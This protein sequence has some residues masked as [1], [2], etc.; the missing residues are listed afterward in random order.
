MNM[1]AT[2]ARSRPVAQHCAELTRRSSRP[3][4]RAEHLAAWRRDV[5]QELAQELGQLFSG[6][7]LQASLAEPEMLG[8]SQVFEKIGPVAVNSLLRCGEGD[9]TVLLSLNHATAIALTDASFG[10]EGMLPEDPPSQLPRS[11]TMLVERVATTIAQVLALVNGADSPRGDVLLRSESATRLKPFGAS[12]EIACFTLSLSIGPFAEWNAL[13]AVANDRLEG[14][15]PGLSAQ[16]SRR[17]APSI[18]QR[19]V[20]ETFGAM[21]L[22]LE[23][24]LG[25]IDLSLD[26]LDRLA[27]GDELPLAITNELPLRT[28]GEVL[29]R[30]TVGTVEN[31][32]ALR[33]TRLTGRSGP[34]TDPQDKG[35]FA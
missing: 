1:A 21:P 14:L 19:A 17:P 4:D 33:V 11:A 15:M 31:R 25:E 29:A 23:A 9:Q 20:S 32:M 7:K 18:E 5:A 12:A 16:R 34:A 26:R 30:G 35:A 2:F 6:G 28:G 10:G 27:P 13:L 3:E 22:P 8:G 24:V